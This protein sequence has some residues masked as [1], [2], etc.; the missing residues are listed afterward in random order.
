MTKKSVATNLLHACH[1]L[2]SLNNVIH[3]HVSTIHSLSK[4]WYIIS[5]IALQLIVTDSDASIV[6]LLLKKDEFAKMR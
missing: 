2:S 1:V 5:Y 4:G 6:R 3:I